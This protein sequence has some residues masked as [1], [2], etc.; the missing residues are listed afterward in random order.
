MRH[1]AWPNSTAMLRPGAELQALLRHA[2]ARLAAAGVEAPR[3]DAGILIGHALGRDRGWVLTH[4]QHAADGSAERCIEALIARRAARE[5]VSRILGKREFWSLDFEL[6]PETLDPRPDSETLIE[7]ALAQLPGRERSW[8]I[9]DLGTGT[10]CLLL[11]LLSERPCATG[12]G[13]DRSA[14]AA[15]TALANARRHGLDGRAH[16]LVGDWALSVDARFDLV[17]CNPPY[18]RAGELVKLAP[19]LA[20]DPRLALA[21]GLDGL[22]CYR[23]I[24][25][26]LRRLL[27]PGGAA[28]LE[29][30]CDQ[31]PAV[32]ALATGAGLQ[33]PRISADLAGR[34]RCVVMDQC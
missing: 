33:K 11:A 3:E 14:A 25:P 5:P 18:I 10:G 6:A 13:I 23:A 31:A 22:D 16:F 30:G 12:V 7:A 26:D 34:P 4:P 24:L 19:E 20:W 15:A 8:R 32:T 17:I 27:A 1:S 2:T 21:G 29:I 28:V 9:L